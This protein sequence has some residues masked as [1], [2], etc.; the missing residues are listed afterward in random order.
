M[1]KL[2][3]ILTVV[4]TT[5]M[6]CGIALGSYQGAFAQE[7]NDVDSE[8][9]PGMVYQFDEKGNYN[10]SDTDN[11]YSTDSGTE[12]DGQFIIT[13]NISS[14][15]E[16]NGIPEYAVNGGPLTFSF[17]YDDDLL[18]A[19]E[20]EDQLVDENAKKVNG[21]ALNSEIKKGALIIQTSKDGEIWFN[22]PGATFT[23]IF[24]D[25]PDGLKEF[26]TT[27]DVQMVNGCYYRI[28]IAFLRI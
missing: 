9:V 8:T 17:N 6:I 16:R 13:G 25:N 3:S 15:S 24:K 23:N 26:Y 1:R 21:T 12:S 7:N 28:L 19:S 2:K 18:K 4:L 5:V 27:T 20:D 22:V 10:L 11:T 14:V